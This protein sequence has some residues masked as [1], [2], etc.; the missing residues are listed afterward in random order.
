[1]Q[2]KRETNALSGWDTARLV[3]LGHPLGR[4]DLVTL[5]DGAALVSWLEAGERPGAA[6]V[7]VR[8]FDRDGRLST[9][10]TV[11]TGSA[12]RASGFARLAARH[13]RPGLALMAWT[14][15]LEEAHGSQR[16]VTQ[17]RTAW[18]D[19]HRFARGQAELNLPG[20]PA[21]GPALLELCDPRA[22]AHAP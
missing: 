22:L 14:D 7:M 10:V 16:A 18:I 1:V 3:D 12:T 20:N 13:E 11:N 17:V 21:R 2:V 19:T 8:R 9:P 5:S 4:V 15:V 6:S